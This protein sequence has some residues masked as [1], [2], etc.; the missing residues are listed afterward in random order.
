MQIAKMLSAVGA[1]RQLLAGV[2]ALVAFW[3]K[4]IDLELLGG[5]AA[6]KPIFEVGADDL[7][8][9]VTRQ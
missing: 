9:C 2:T 1:L 6:I 5:S 8:C 4:R 7:S 3:H